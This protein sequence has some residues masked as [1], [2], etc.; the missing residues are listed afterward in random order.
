MTCAVSIYGG[1][2][3]RERYMAKELDRIADRTV[4]SVHSKAR[5]VE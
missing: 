3:L 1:T 2:V 4:M 5:I